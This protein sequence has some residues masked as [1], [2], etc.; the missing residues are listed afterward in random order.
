MYLKE[1]NFKLAVCQQL[2]YMMKHYGRKKE[3]FQEAVIFAAT[4]TLLPRRT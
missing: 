4:T 1:K 2:L 3:Y